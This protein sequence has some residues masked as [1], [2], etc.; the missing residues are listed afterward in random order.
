VVAPLRRSPLVRVVTAEAI[1]SLG[2]RM[3]LVAL[4]WFVLHTTGSAAL[5]GVAFAVESLPVLLFGLASGPLLAR[6]GALRAMVVADA[7]RAAILGAVPFLH[8]A[9][10]LPFG[11]LMALLFACGTVSV[12]HFSAQRIALAEIG[13]GEAAT[14]R[15]N[16]W[17]E[18]VQQGATVIGPALAGVLVALVGAP[19]V[20]GIDAVTFALSAAI[21]VPLA[22]GARPAPTAGETPRAL[23]GVR[24]IARDRAL[25]PLTMVCVLVELTYLPAL[26]VALPVWVSERGAPAS[27]LGLLLAAMAGG[28]L[29]GALAL[30]RLG[31]R[32]PT[33]IVL[34]GAV[35]MVPSWLPLALGSGPALGALGLAAGG[36][37]NT[38]CRAGMMTALTHAVPVALRAPVMTA[39]ITVVIAAQPLGAGAGGPLVEAR[40]TAAVFGLA[41][42]A[43]V[44]LIA[45][46]T[47]THRRTMARPDAAPEGAAPTTPIVR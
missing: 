35:L 31:D 16:G 1:S 2:T 30:Q 41:V 3:S 33:A 17:L 38:I 11:V 8:A 26:V 13:G 32:P 47:L 15:A 34:L 28:S 4:P 23:T 45:G 7:G 46:A 25:R 44:V 6:V 10:A 19:A 27:Q 39:F 22:R 37:G 40:G 14:A 5:T 18:T 24:H 20:V 9:G 43:T 36:V 42:L 12:P 21:L 29:A